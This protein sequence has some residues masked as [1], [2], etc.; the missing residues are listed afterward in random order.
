[1]KRQKHHPKHLLTRRDF[2]KISGLS[3]GAL[4]LNSWNAPPGFAKEVYPTSKI[5]FIVPHQP[6]GGHDTFARTLS[7]FITKYL[8]ELSPGAKGGDIQIKNESAGAG[9]KGRDLLFRSKPDGYTIGIMDTAPITDSIVSGESE[10]DF[11]K[12]TFLLLGATITKL[13]V[14]H[15]NGFNS[16]SEVMN[17]LKKEPIKLGVAQFGRGNHVSAI[18]MNEK[19]GTR[20]KLIPFTGSAESMNALIRGDVPITVAAEDAVTGLLQ[21][22]EIKVLLSFTHVSEYPGAVT[23][24]DLGFPELVDQI[25]NH[26]FI[27][28][29]PDLAPEAK[30]LLIGAIKKATTDKEFLALA[31]K[32]N[33]TLKNMYG[34]EAERMFLQFIK[35]YDTIGPTLKKHL[36]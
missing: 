24:K 35:F 10:F 21:A 29:P 32:A 33:F 30:T 27:V 11:T 6:G 9:R 4:T 26:R 5:T 18:I 7:P 34:D 20:F 13:I 12:L 2:L 16:W 3:A 8:K 31:Q 23:I 28:A 1:M 25:N 17:A 22:K 19:L 14:T 15:K 36:S